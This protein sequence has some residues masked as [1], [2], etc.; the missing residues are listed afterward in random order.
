MT[1]E[2][3]KVIKDSGCVNK[4]QLCDFLECIKCQSIIESMFINDIERD[5][6]DL[7]DN[8]F[9]SIRKKKEDEYYFWY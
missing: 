2:Q 7:S 8:A 4:E 3:M 9:S 5:I 1:N 6:N